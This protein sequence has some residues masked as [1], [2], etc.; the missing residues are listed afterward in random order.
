[1]KNDLAIYENEELHDSV[2]VQ[3]SKFLRQFDTQH[4]SSVNIKFDI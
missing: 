4:Q 1:M 2:K 3:V